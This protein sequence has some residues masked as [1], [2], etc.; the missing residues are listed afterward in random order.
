MVVTGAG[1][2]QVAEFEGISASCV[3]PELS[4]TL[5]AAGRPNWLAFRG[6]AGVIS[7]PRC[8]E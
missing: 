7:I 6:L 2:G 4:S 8:G 1:S 3:R 5:V